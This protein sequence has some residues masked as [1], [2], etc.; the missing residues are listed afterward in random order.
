MKIFFSTMLFSVL[1]HSI[2]MAAGVMSNVDQNINIE[3]SF[4]YSDIK[5]ITSVTVN[6]NK[7]EDE[8]NNGKSL[9]IGTIENNRR[10]ATNISNDVN[11][12]NSKIIST[13]RGGKIGAVIYE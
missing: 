13:A 3:S 12:K 10:R 9:E 7:V 6:G 11:L 8:Y 2:P 1:M 5:G 4:I